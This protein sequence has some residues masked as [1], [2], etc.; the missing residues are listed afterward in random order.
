M[1]E[2]TEMREIVKEV[3]ILNLRRSNIGISNYIKSNKPFLICKISEE[4]GGLAISKY[5]NE[6]PKNI[7]L[8]EILS[9]VRNKAGIYSNNPKDYNDYAGL[10]YDIIKNSSAIAYLPA[11]ISQLRTFAEINFYNNLK[12]IP[13]IH[14]ESLEPYYATMDNLIPWSH[15]LLGKKVLIVHPFTDS[16][17]IQ[18]K[19]KFKIYPQN[20]IFLEGQEFIFYKSY[21]TAGK[22][23]IHKDWKETFQ[24]MCSEISKLDFDIA[25][26]GCGGYGVPLAGFIYDKLKKPA[27]QIGG[28]L[29]L[30]FGVMGKRWENTEM[31]E[32]IIREQECK[33]IKPSGDEILIN[34]HLVNDGCYW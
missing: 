27:I 15:Q 34:K 5:Y 12:D 31:W 28:G 2:Q 14:H 4:C 29:Q 22:N 16:F 6:L 17:K 19:N 21:N 7:A 26:I 8:Y 33:F 3:P 9:F 23:H 32:T 25:L 18:I 11:N 1:E 10:Y 20:P 13:P 24:R 30:L